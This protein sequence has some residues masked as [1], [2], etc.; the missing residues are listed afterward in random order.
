MLAAL[1]HQMFEQVGGA[2]GPGDLVAR[3]HVISDLETSNRCGMVGFDQDLQAVGVEPI[4]VDAAN[5]LHERESGH[6]RRGPHRGESREY[7]S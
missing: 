1:E 3:A 2:R 5:R 7:Q 4:F 6:A